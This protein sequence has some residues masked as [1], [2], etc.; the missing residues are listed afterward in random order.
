MQV[1]YASLVPNSTASIYHDTK[2]AKT[3]ASW[4]S[5]GMEIDV[6]RQIALRLERMLN[7]PGPIDR[8]SLESFTWHLVLRYGRCFDS[9][10]AG[11]YAALGIEHVR[12]LNDADFLTIHEGLIHRRHN[13]FAHPGGDCSCRVN[14]HLI[15]QAGN[16]TLHVGHDEEG[17]GPINDPE[18]AALIARLCAALHT[19]VEDK[20]ERARTA[21]GEEL[22]AEF[23]AL[24]ATLRASA[25]KHANPTQQALSIF[26]RLGQ[27]PAEPRS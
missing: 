24:V 19:V 12:K 27:N 5:I 4:L 26:A 18:Q 11:R 25:G 13:T 23:D 10:S 21:H 1:N 7:A 16:T 8:L 3:Y 2:R 6:V 15:E 14:L 22:A 20:V 17:P 9:T